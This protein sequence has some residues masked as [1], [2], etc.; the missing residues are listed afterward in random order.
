[1]NRPAP[2]PRPATGVRVVY[3][4]RPDPRD[5]EQLAEVLARLLARVAGR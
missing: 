4:P 3:A 1:M 5:V 2:K